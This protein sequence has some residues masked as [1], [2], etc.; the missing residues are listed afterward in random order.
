L[1][2]VGELASNAQLLTA[3]QSAQTQ[4]GRVINP[5]L[6]S[7][8]EFKQRVSE[9]RSFIMR[10]LEQPKIFVKGV[11]HDIA[12]LSAISQPGTDK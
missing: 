9:G 10:V 2:V 6:Y 5:T 11:E 8:D 1:M 12:R 7:H 4:L 3:L